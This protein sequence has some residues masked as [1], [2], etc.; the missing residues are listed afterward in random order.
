MKGQLN[1]DGGLRRGGE[2]GFESLGHSWSG[3]WDI[4]QCER[5]N[6]DC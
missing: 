5:V 4:D 3:R 2:L 1:T 6:V